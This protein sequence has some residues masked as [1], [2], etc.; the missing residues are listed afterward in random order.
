MPLNENSKKTLPVRFHY[1]RLQMILVVAAL[2]RVQQSLGHKQGSLVPKTRSREANCRPNTTGFRDLWGR[3]LEVI[4]SIICS[5]TVIRLWNNFGTGDQEVFLLS[6]A[7][8]N[9][10]SSNVKQ[11]DIRISKFFEVSN[12]DSSTYSGT[13]WMSRKTTGSCT[14]REEVRRAGE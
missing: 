2:D 14:S 9:F 4:F 7:L 8:V 6:S 12:F 1:A 13:F 10:R 5:P 11:T 3:A